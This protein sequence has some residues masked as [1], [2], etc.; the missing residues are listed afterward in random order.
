MD[1]LTRKPGIALI[2]PVGIKAGLDAYDSGLA[3]ELAEIGYPVSVYS[4]FHQP[5][6][7]VSYVQRF[8]T[9]QYRWWMLFTLILGYRATLRECHAAGV[10]TLIL[11]FFHFNRVDVWLTELA[12]RMGFR[13]IGIV[14]DVEGFVHP[15]RLDRLRLIVDECLDQIVVHN[16]FTRDELLRVAGE[17]I[18]HRIF[19]IPHGRFPLAGPSDQTRAAALQVLSLPDEPFRILFFGM[20]K[21][22]KGLETLL[23]AMHDLPSDIQLLIAGRPRPG[24]EPA[25]MKQVRVLE[26]EGRARVFLQAIPPEQVSHYFQAADIAVLPYHRVYQSGVLLRA[27]SEGLP[28][29]LSDLPP[30]REIAVQG[31]E[32][33]FFKAGDAAGLARAILRLKED[34]SLRASLQQ[35]ARQKLISRHDW[36]AVAREFS[37]LLP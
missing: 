17:A 33:L 3:T 24:T 11:H 23:A 4:N 31:K 36:T 16:R 14:H 21:P 7:P 5:S 22:T 19:V 20:I 28:V 2:D 13:V 10:H 34:P 30:F 27:W 8:S 25:T 12:R 37:N 1:P 15:T 29:V 6:G 35:S 32:A 9:Q 18:A 26:R